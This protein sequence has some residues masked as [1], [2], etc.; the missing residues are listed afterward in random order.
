MSERLDEGDRVNLGTCCACGKSGQDV[1]NVV[2]LN[3]KGPTPGKG[4]GCL[5]CGL[6]AD[7]AVAVLCDDCLE[8]GEEIRF[9][10]VGYAAEDGRMP[11]AELPFE[12]FEH[13]LAMH[14]W[15]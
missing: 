9:V 6:P 2:M 5:V 1:H 12:P 4:W 3:R 8:A 11:I 13:R 10:C 14:W 15:E 7:G